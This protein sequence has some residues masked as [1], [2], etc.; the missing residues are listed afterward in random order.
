MK[1]LTSDQIKRVDQFTIKNKKISSI[2]LMENAALACSKWIKNKF[3]IQH[4]FIFLCGNGNNGGD[5]LAIARNLS[6][7]GYSSL[8][9]EYIIKRK[10]SKDYLINKKRLPFKTKALSLNSLKKLSID[11]K[12]IFVDSIIGSGLNRH[13]DDSLKEVINWINKNAEKIISIDIPTGMYTEYN[14]LNKYIIKASYTLTFQ[15]PKLSFMLPEAGNSVGD[16][17]ILDIG[18]DKNYIKEL[19]SNFFYNTKKS[20]KPFF[21]KYKKF[22]HKGK[23]G[24]LLLVAGSRGKIGASVLAGKVSFFSGLGK[25]TICTPKCGAETIQT[26]LPEAML[27]I[28][29]GQN[30]LSG[31]LISKIKVIA[32]GPGIGTSKSTISY[33]QSIIKNSSS[34]LIID[35]D[36]LNIISKNKKLMNDLPENSILTPHP[37]ELERLV[38]IWK[39]DQDKLLKL[40]KLSF[41]Y[42]VIV[43]LKGAHTCIS[44]PSNEIWFNSSGNPGMATAGSGDVLTGLLGGFLAQGYSPNI[45]A[46]IAVYLHGSAADIGSKKLSQETIISGDIQKYLSEAIKKLY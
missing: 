6:K 33:V 39:N 17:K 3:S 41:K 7:D 25:L 27:E 11:K 18:L 29:E 22:D 14:S 38:G 28:N 45:C 23:R 10:S 30:Y 2:Q 40:R 31:K 9:F 32:I 24:H 26:S 43:I 36:A 16:F 12:H 4:K 20:L 8:C 13:L 19:S 42:K 35:A 21:K 5:G 44:L 37:K 1:I 34:P 46:R 15:F